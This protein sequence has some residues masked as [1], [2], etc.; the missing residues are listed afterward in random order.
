M[1]NFYKAFL[2]GFIGLATLSAADPASATPAVSAVPAAPVA[3]AP[4]TNLAPAPVVHHKPDKEFEKCQL[5]RGGVL[6]EEY[7]TAL[8]TKRFRNEFTT[9]QWKTILLQK[10]IRIPLTGPDHRA[11][12]K[13]FVGEE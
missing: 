3:P 13:L 8:H 5:K 2:V 7:A 1:G 10:R 9:A 11:M 4:E 6:Y 12:L